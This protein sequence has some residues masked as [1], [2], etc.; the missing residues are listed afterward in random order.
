MAAWYTRRMREW[1]L[2]LVIVAALALGI[3]ANLAIFSGLDAVL[4][5]SLPVGQPWQI[6][7]ARNGLP[8]QPD[9]EFSSAVVRQMRAAVPTAQL[10]C[11]TEGYEMFTPRPG[12]PPQMVATQLVSPNY[13]T[14]LGVR[15]TRGRVLDSGD[16]AALA[17]VLGYAYWLQHYDGRP[18]VGKT[19]TLNGV[20]LDIIGIAPPGFY[21][22]SKARPADAWVPM[23]LQQRLH[24]AGSAYMDSGRG[25]VDPTKPWD[26]Q[27]GIH[28]LN[29][30]ARIPGAATAP[31]IAAAATA[32]E[33]NVEAPYAAQGP[34]SRDAVWFVRGSTGLAYL[35]KEIA[36]PLELLLGMAG[37]VLLIACADVAL[38][39]LARGMSRRRE[40]AVRLALGAGQGRLLRNALAS[41]LALAALGAGLGLALAFWGRSALMALLGVRLPAGTVALDARVLSFSVAT[42][43]ITGLLFGLAPAWLAARVNVNEALKSEGGGQQSARARGWSWLIG[44]QVALS[45]VLLL[46]ASLLALSLVRLL[47][48]RPGFATASVISATIAPR[49]AGYTP[50]TF[51]GLE[52]RLL[53]ARLN[54]EPGVASATIASI[55]VL[56][57]NSY[58][59]TLSVE[60]NGVRHVHTEE[61]SVSPGFF[62][63]LGI[64]L[65]RGRRFRAGDDAHAPQVVIVNEV[66][67]RRYLTDCQPLGAVINDF[68]DATVVG[69]VADARVHGADQ[70]VPPMVYHPQ[71]QDPESSHF[72]AVRFRGDAS[73][74]IAEIRSALAQIA[75]TMPVISLHTLQDRLRAGLGGERALADLSGAFAL[76]ALLL[77]AL[78]IYG[79]MSYAVAR[80]EQEVGIRMAL[81]ARPREILLLVLQS[82]LTIVGFGLAAG[83][84]MALPLA[85][86][87][88]HGL[89]GL[90]P[91]DPAAIALSLGVLLLVAVAAAALPALRASRV[92]PWSAL[93]R[94]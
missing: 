60:P 73:A 88:R 6:Y 86:L 45:L 27:S 44:A 87:L 57:G 38:L 55:G 90:S 80:R 69:V 68:R 64:P 83:L 54:A 91:L 1:K 66:F 93:R 37:L 5:R 59:S 12:A 74:G 34:K 81:G 7:F 50:A 61:D 43:V 77:A 33:R 46:A 17:A 11:F 13:F 30:V 49:S 21:G 26:T 28:W 25:A 4:L 41:S 18:V 3:G 39:L 70:P 75:P 51:P 82:A 76:L 84:A 24:Y 2:H 35:S 89:H 92:V 14:L 48:L 94:E 36:A 22:L 47:R 40:W 8:S 19:I 10:A 52:H 9:T 53:L 72:L 32:A 29:V 78:G 58:G 63:T 67:V 42:A 56:A 79:V 71:A 20:A 31:G 16:A 62:S 23:G 65:L 15:A 85:H